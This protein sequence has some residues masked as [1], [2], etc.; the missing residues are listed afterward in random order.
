MSLS[1]CDVTRG[2]ASEG[3]DF[4]DRAGRAVIVTGIPYAMKTDPQVRIKKEVLDQECRKKKPGNGGPSLVKLTGDAWYRQQASRAVNQALGRVIRHKDDYG[5][6]I[7]LDERFRQR[8]VRKDLSKWLQPH[9]REFETFGAAAGALTKFFRN[10][11]TITVQVE[12]SPARMPGG[13]A[14]AKE[15]VH[16]G[17]V[18]EAGSGGGFQVVREGEG[19]GGMGGKGQPRQQLPASLG[20]RFDLTG[21]STFASK[22]AG[23]NGKDANGKAA[24]RGGGSRK[25]SLSEV[26]A[27]SKKRKAAMSPPPPIAP[28]SVSI[29]PRPLIA[30]KN[31]NPP[32]ANRVA[33]PADKIQSA[34]AP[35]KQFLLLAKSLY[36]K[37]DYKKFSKL[38]ASYKHTRISIS[39]LIGELKRM[40]QYDQMPLMR[41]LEQ[42]V[43]TK[44][45]PL[46]RELIG[47]GDRGA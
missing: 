39:D 30:L 29:R 12:G 18:R 19:V 21:L 47:G 34:S 40:G 7:L 20:A 23:G 33:P 22:F 25:Q 27:A 36:S 10:K 31:Q 46:Y 41:A 37:D 45:V 42:F 26:L 8:D 32:P 17:G 14:R 11:R 9:V 13:Q 6:I 44:D 5:A 16:G 4:S 38:F 3:L 28:Q 35:A 15:G 1:H 24:G 2:K 43:F